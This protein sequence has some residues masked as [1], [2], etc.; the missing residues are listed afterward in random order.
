V[1][2]ERTILFGPLLDEH[3]LREVVE[4]ERTVHWWGF[5]YRITPRLVSTKLGDGLGLIHFTPLNTRPNYYMVRVD[6]SLVDDGH[7]GDVGLNSDHFYDDVLP[8]IYE[9]I[10]ED[11]GRADWPC[12]EDENAEPD[13]FPALNDDVGSC[14]G[15]I[16]ARWL[17]SDYARRLLDCPC[18]PAR[19]WKGEVR[20]AYRLADHARRAAARIARGAALLTGAAGVG[21]P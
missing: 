20:E 4:Y 19:W 3:V 1:P 17:L 7:D 14:W 13:P 12:E 2:R 10:E 15:R 11:F 9:A 5:D 21:L 16:D 8:D 6:S 18:R